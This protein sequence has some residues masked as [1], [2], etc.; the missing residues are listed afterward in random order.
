M[1]RS[2]T[3]APPSLDYDKSSSLASVGDD[4]SAI[5]QLGLFCCVLAGQAA[6]RFGLGRWH[7]LCVG[8]QAV[9]DQFTGHSLSVTSVAF[10]PDGQ[11]IA[12]DSNNCTIRVWDASTGEVVAGPFN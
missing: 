1:K 9:V 5:W 11:R 8:R 4:D 2:K 10:P 7:E 6:H 12:S 3:T